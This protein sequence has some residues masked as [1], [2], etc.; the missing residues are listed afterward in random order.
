[1]AVCVPSTRVLPASRAARSGDRLDAAGAVIVTAG[2]MLAVYAIVNGNQ[3][4]WRSGRTV[5]LLA[6]SVALL[7]AFV[8]V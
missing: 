1:M 2:L 8:G 7:M 6:G 4:G 3:V 5:G